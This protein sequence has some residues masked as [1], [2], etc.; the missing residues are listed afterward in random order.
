MAQ[1]A[2]LPFEQAWK[3]VVVLENRNQ[4]IPI[5]DLTSLQAAY[6]SPDGSV[7]A[8]QQAEFLKLFWR[9]APIELVSDPAATENFN[10]FIYPTTQA[11]ISPAKLDAL[12]KLADRGT[13][14]TLLIGSEE[15]WLQCPLLRFSDAVLYLTQPSE[16]AFQVVPQILF[17]GLAAKGRLARNLGMQ[18][19]VYVQGL[20]VQTKGG[21]RLSYVP[22]QVAAMDADLLR[23]SLRT[24]V[25]EG[26]AKKAYPGAQVLVA[27]AGQVVFFETFG[28]HTYEAKKA[29]QEDD[30]YDFA[31]VTKVT[32]ALAALIKLHGEGRFNLDATFPT[33]WPDMEGSNKDTLTFRE[34]L[35]H[36]AKLMPWIPYWRTTLRGNARYPWRK[37]WDG[38]MLNDYKFKWWTFKR[39]SSRRYP[40]R[41]TDDLWLHR[42]YKDKIYKAIRKSPLNE[43]EGYVYSGLLF[44]ILPEMVERMV[45]QDYET[46][47]Q[48]QFYR[49]L[50][51]NTIG[52]NPYQRFPL[53]RIVPTEV[54]TFF[55]M[56]K[57]HGTVHDEGA[58]MMGGVSANAGL[59]GTANDLA[60]LFQ[61]YQ[62]GGTYGGA[63][64]LAKASLDTFNTRYFAEAENRRG[65]GFDKPLL[66][67]DAAKSYVAQS[68]SDASFGHSGYTG[69]FVWADPEKELLFIFFSNRVYPS[70]DNRALYIHNLRPRMHQA[71][72]DA[73]EKPM[74]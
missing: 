10:Y 7:N 17:G 68:A 74:E 26:I 66:E 37:R 46:Y 59:F 27:K 58:A 19:G 72:Y 48:E 22:P 70:R 62:N 40:V 4:A 63:V 56:Q 73:L 60:K 2:T 25:Q 23:D 14:V 65:L 29:V 61:M 43:K 33:Y 8:T 67:Y 50:G 54:D 55:R 53:E 42:S 30:L 11:A 20:G 57:L 64:Y 32:S 69:T 9:Y 3:S 47:L 44:Y 71:V 28:H 21:L 52:Y 49:P 35:S 1:D 45:G 12:R 51:A 24:I 36:H 39:D 6:L 31:S 18:P 5:G 38:A 34:M 13:L 41:I 16:I 15:D